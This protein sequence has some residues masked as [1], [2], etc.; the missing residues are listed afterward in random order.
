MS[1]EWLN[2]YLASTS[3]A[4]AS[5]FVTRAESVVFGSKGAAVRLLEMDRSGGVVIASSAVTGYGDAEVY[6]KIVS[7]TGGERFLSAPLHTA[8]ELRDVAKL[9]LNILLPVGPAG[10]PYVALFNAHCV[11]ETM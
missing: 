8:I 2:L 1:R 9:E 10:T 3:N 5:Q 11:Y 4:P 6:L 7:T